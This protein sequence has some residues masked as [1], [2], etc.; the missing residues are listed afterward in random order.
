MP[1]QLYAS[2]A[3][4]ILSAI[5]LL[6]PA[7]AQ[8]SGN[9]DSAEAS[10]VAADRD[11]YLEVFI[12]GEPA[13][14]IG[15]FRQYA[16][17]TFAATPE[18][19]RE[20]GIAPGLQAVGADGLVSL[21]D[22]A[23]TSF[24]YDEMAQTIRF[25]VEDSARAA[26]V[27]SAN[28][29][30]GEEEDHP[31][32]E[33][34]WGGVL[35]YSLF[36]AAGTDLDPTTDADAFKGF[37][38]SF[39]ARL[40]SPLGVLSNSFIGRLAPDSAYGSTRLDTT[41]SYSD[42]KRLVTY[43][44]GDMVSG[45]L[46][47][48]R[49]VRLAGA[50]VQRN[51]G[52]RSDLVTLP[53]PTFSGSAAVPSTLEIYTHNIKTYSEEVKAGP[54]TVTDIPI[55]TGPGTAQIVVRD[56][57]G[58]ERTEEVQFYVSSDLLRPGL[59][60]FSGEAGY[61]RRSYG[62]ESFDYYDSPFGSFSL[63][64]GLLDWLTAEAHLEGGEALVNGGAG[65]SVGLDSWGVAS[66]ALAASH[67]EGA[68][69]AQ[70]SASVELDFRHFSLFGRVQRTFGD[71]QD[72]ASVTAL[73]EESEDSSLDPR[74]P[75]DVKQVA[76][77]IPLKFDPTSLRFSYTELTDAEGESRR[78]GSFS[79]GRP[80]PGGASV[81]ASAFADL[82]SDDRFGAFIGF[83]MPLGGGMMASS[84]ATREADGYVGYAEIAKTGSLEPG[85]VGWRLR[86]SKSDNLRAAAAASY[87]S[88]VGRIKAEVDKGENGVR[89]SAELEGA[90]AVA[91]GGIFVTN[92]I[93]DAFAVVDA[94]APGVDVLYENRL[95]G[96]TGQQGRFIIPNLRSFEPN[97]ISIDP[98]SLP[99]DAQ[100]AATS[101]V[102]V[103][104][105]RAAVVVDFGISTTTPAALVSFRDESGDPLAVGSVLRTEAAGEEVVIGYDGEGYLQNLAGEN[106]VTITKPDGGVCHATFAYERRPGEQTRIADVICMSME[107]AT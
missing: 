90:I 75:K 43:R 67:A 8:E 83:S 65:A 77:S 7:G 47:W 2:R 91:G 9:A 85:S 37:S 55:V 25:A 57:E 86:A 102:A 41:W 99:V 40:V 53:L 54:F 70:A 36:A 14:L 35:N 15:S 88:S 48:T 63:R 5:L 6:Q 52:L 89:A 76:I 11:L 79:L 49:P 59:L 107:E 24:E 60:D 104:A 12:N 78:I 32:I 28:S 103:P 23:S 82:E 39:D 27:L 16:D 46:G 4:V 21:D 94:G 64:Y 50:Q 22:L 13:D 73:M 26:K 97:S 45:G 81:H 62:T 92:R 84:G 105:E 31:P 20:I 93:D 72:I 1:R 68:V 87:R 71:Y 69:G 56:A 51:F 18:E 98:K 29:Q 74:P 101:H 30:S 58:R 100:I 61:P 44:V 33:A 17:G 96:K 106:R 95:A 38:G 34:R 10:A 80:L 19:L 42:P 66:A 3:I